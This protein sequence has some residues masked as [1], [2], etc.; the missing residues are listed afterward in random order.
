MH[1][2]E[3][4]SDDGWIRVRDRFSNSSLQHDGQICYR[5]SGCGS[6]MTRLQ[7]VVSSELPP[8]LLLLRP[9]IASR[10]TS[11]VSGLLHAR[12]VQQLNPGD[13]VVQLGLGSADLR[14]NLRKILESPSVE[15]EKSQQDDWDT[16]YARM[17]VKRNVPE[18]GMSAMLVLP[19][20]RRHTVVFQVGAVKAY[21]L[22]VHPHPS[23]GKVVVS[24]VLFLPFSAYPTW[25]TS[26]FSE[27]TTL[28]K[29]NFIRYLQ[30][31]D[32]KSLCEMDQ[33]YYTILNLR[34]CNRGV[35]LL[36]LNDEEVSHLTEDSSYVVI[37]GEDGVESYWARW[38][39]NE[40]TFHAYLKDFLQRVGIEMTVFT[41]L[42]GRKL[43]P[44]QVAVLSHQWTQC[45][46][47]VIAEFHR[48]QRA[49]RRMNGGVSAPRVGEGPDARFLHLPPRPKSA[50]FASH[51]ED[52]VVRRTFIDMDDSVVDLGSA[53][54]G[55]RN[56][57]G[58]VLV[59]AAS[60][61]F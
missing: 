23:P 60:T 24:H 9:E 4:T 30:A 29:E 6:C 51:S 56:Q 13:A 42:S 37:K 52:V 12:Y 50:C 61:H 43:V 47:E 17:I 35:P 7:F 19:I 25:A 10:T 20:G 33:Q 11:G 16:Y 41:E 53:W 46:E 45:R 27:L 28:E 31:E 57:V 49:Y 14:H 18:P 58:G 48:Q 39:D 26:Y 8:E 38:N 21:T 2:S 32:L 5:F 36:P 40:F 22:T 15:E 3:A 34:G 59:R 44:Y 55:A 54:V 1:I